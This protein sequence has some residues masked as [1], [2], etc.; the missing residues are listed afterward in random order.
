M[1]QCFLRDSVRV[2]R[3]V[4][5]GRERHVRGP[6]LVAPEGAQ[7]SDAIL[8]KVRLPSL[9]FIAVKYVPGRWIQASTLSYCVC[10]IFT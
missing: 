4:R 9:R 5:R 1:S 10:D 2:V 3:V 8:A 7:A 6:V